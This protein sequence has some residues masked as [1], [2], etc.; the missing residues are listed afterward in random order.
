ML[1][2]RER[3]DMSKFIESVYSEYGERLG[4]LVLFFMFKELYPNWWKI[5][6]QL[7]WKTESIDRVLEKEVGDPFNWDIIVPKCAIYVELGPEVWY[8]ELRNLSILPEWARQKLE[9]ARKKFLS[10]KNIVKEKYYFHEDLLR[11]AHLDGYL[12]FIHRGLRLCSAKLYP[13]VIATANHDRFWGGTIEIAAKLYGVDP[14]QVLNYVLTLVRK[15]IGSIAIYRDLVGRGYPEDKR[16]Y[17]DEVKPSQLLADNIAFK[18]HRGGGV[19]M[20]LVWE[21]RRVKHLYELSVK[22]VDNWLKTGERK[23]IDFT[24]VYETKSSPYEY[25]N[26][27]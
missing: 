4:N 14:Y 24:L 8:P 1:V 5:H 9:E 19:L 16:I 22:S 25:F 20:D 7:E 11:T 6:F 23:Y 10:E 12:L 15:G 26:S 18:S 2:K 21:F 27:E 13:F 17:P 3:G